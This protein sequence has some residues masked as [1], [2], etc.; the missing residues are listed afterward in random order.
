MELLDSFIVVQLLAVASRICLP[1]MA[2]C[3]ACQQG[4]YPSMYH[5]CI[6]YQE[7]YHWNEDGITKFLIR[8]AIKMSKGID[9]GRILYKWKMFFRHVFP[10][11]ASDNPPII[12]EEMWY[13]LVRTKLYEYAMNVR[14]LLES[15]DILYVKCERKVFETLTLQQIVDLYPIHDTWDDT[16]EREYLLANRFSDPELDFSKLLSE[17]EEE[18][19]E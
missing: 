1:S 6:N 12:T 11:L 14:A 18:E 3:D 8:G 2:E 4:Y 9:N 13:S 16:F 10:D 5:P 15:Y 19:T 7:P 17:G